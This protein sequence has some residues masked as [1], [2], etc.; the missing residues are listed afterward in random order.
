MVFIFILHTHLK[1]KHKKPK[2]SHN[3]D[4]TSQTQIYI[5]IFILEA[6]E[7]KYLLYFRDML[8]YFSEK[9]P[10]CFL[11]LGGWKCTLYS[12]S[13]VLSTERDGYMAVSSISFCRLFLPIKCPTAHWGVCLR[14]TSI[15]S[16]LPW[17]FENSTQ[18]EWELKE[19]SRRL[20]RKAM[21]RIL[22]ARTAVM[23]VL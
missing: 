13:R 16:S 6:Q 2:L 5:Y 20:A 18:T 4:K 3:P 8:K 15:L 23:S 7:N 19:K 22:M 12:Y 9:C 17:P 21:G 14:N 1:I 11:H 10:L